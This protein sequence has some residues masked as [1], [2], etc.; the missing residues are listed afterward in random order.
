MLHGMVVRGNAHLPRLRTD[1]TSITRPLFQLQGRDRTKGKPVNR[2]SHRDEVAGLRA[3]GLRC[4]PLAPRRA[5]LAGGA[6]S[7]VSG[8]GRSPQLRNPAKVS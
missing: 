3:C 7:P 1:V 6:F 4:G 8:R 5:P 2:R